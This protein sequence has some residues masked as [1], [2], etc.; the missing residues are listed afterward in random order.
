MAHVAAV[1]RN[2]GS[3]HPDAVYSGRGPFLPDDVVAQS[4]PWEDYQLADSR[5]P[6]EVDGIE[7]DLFHGLRDGAEG[8][9]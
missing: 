2:N 3:A 9:P 6:V 4:Y 5:V 8:S 7:D 1:I